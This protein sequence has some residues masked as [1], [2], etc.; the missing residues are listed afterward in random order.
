MIGSSLGR[1]AACLVACM[2]TATAS[3]ADWP[4]WRYDAAR[5]AA[6]PEQL[7]SELHLQW[8]REVSPR[9]PA[10]DDT[11]NRD[12]MTYDRVFEPI[13]L[14]GRLFVGFN[15]RD[16]LVAYDA[17][18]GAEL[19][20]FDTSG[21][22]RLPPVGWQGRVYFTSD[23]GRL[24]CVNAADGTLHWQFQGGP[25]GRQAIGN[26]RVISAW[27][28]RGGPVIR[29]GQV[30]FASSIWP[31]MGVFIYALN[32]QTGDVVWV[33]DDTG[34]QYIRQPHSAPSF[35]GVGPQGALVATQDVL[36]VPGGRSVPAAFDRHTGRQLYFEINAGGKGTGGSFVAANEE[37]WFVH[38]REKGTR[39]FALSNGVKTA[40]QPNEPVLAGDRIYSAEVVQ[41]RPIIRA[42]EAQTKTVLWEVD[43]DGRGDLILAGDTLYA[44]GSSGKLTAIRVAQDKPAQ[45][46]WSIPVEGQVERLLAANGQLFAVTLEGRIMAFG[47]TAPDTPAVLK[48]RMEPLAVDAA[49]EKLVSELL[50]ASPAEGYALWI[51]AEQTAL[52]DAL[53]AQS[54]FV[55]LKI[56]DEQAARVAS[57]RRRFDAAGLSGRV[58]VQPTPLEEFQPP[59][60]VFHTTIVGP[61]R[62][63]ILAG[64]PQ[65]MARIYESVR[66]YG[67]VLHLLADADQIPALR[68]DVSALK[69]ERAEVETTPHGVLIRRVGSLAGAGEWTHQYGDVAN[70]IKSNDQRVKLPLGI[71]WFGG[72]SHE[73]VLPRHG[74]GPPEQVVGGRLFIQGTNSLSARDVY[75]GR[76]L[77]KRDFENLGT[78]DVY[79]DDTYKETPLDTAYNQVHIPGANARGTNYVVTSDRVYIVEG[80]VCHVL[81][82]ATGESLMDIALPQVDPQQPNEWGFIGVSEDVLIGGVGFAKYRDRH[83]L[84]TTAIDSVL[85]RSKAGFGTKSLDRAASLALVGFDRRTGQQLW[86]VDAQHSFWHNGIV[87][88]NG[89]VFALDRNPKPVEEFLRRRG[90]SN[91]ESYRILAFDLRTGE[92]AWETVGDVFGTWL[93][94]SAAHD[95]LLQAGA[96][97]SDRLT[98]EVGQGMA[99]YQGRDG[100]VAWRKDDLKYTGPCVL[101]NDLIITN[102]N[103]YA[104]SA[105]A[106]HIVDGSPKYIDNPLTGAKQPWK[107]TRA[108]GCNN[109]IASEHLLTFRSGA[110]GFYDLLTES[111]TGNFGGF[112]SGCTSNLVVADGVLNAPDY[113][114]TCSCAYQN[115]TSLALVHMP[116]MDA[117][118]ISNS[119]VLEPDG[120]PVRHLGINLGA[121]GDCRDPHGVMWLE[122]PAVAGDS[123][124]LSIAFTGEPR[125]FQHHS[126]T[127]SGTVMSGTALPW[128][129][130]SGVEG[131]A[132]LRLQ[133]SAAPRFTLA[134]GWPIDHADDDAE[135][136]PD[137]EVTLDSSA[138]ELVRAEQDQILGLR[139]NNVPLERGVT[140]RAAALQFTCRSPGDEPTELVIRAEAV[141]NA[142]RF[143]DKARNLSGR[144]LTT[145]TV[146]WTPPAWIKEGDAAAAQRTPDLSPLIQ[147]IVSRPDWQPGNAIA[148]VITG[149]GRRFATAYRGKDSF[150]TQLVIDAETPADAK[151][152]AVAERPY[153]VRLHFGAPRGLSAERRRFDVV[154]NGRPVL[155]NVTLSAEQPA[156]V[157]TLDRVLL[158]D[159]LELDFLSHEGQPLLS[160]IEL[161]RLDE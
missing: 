99:V 17:S 26:R 1:I 38:T 3:A 72:N 28:A 141:G 57:L 125:Y 30:Y 52:V 148:F 155:E 97:G 91:P 49:S 133:L 93:G 9:E 138:L 53:A 37:S 118:T 130:S 158:G 153:R 105:G 100:A 129:L 140:I 16:K 22:V 69:L 110:A 117:W 88:G 74:H 102:A 146:R 27:P 10:W 152:P 121:P 151:R 56:V 58:T 35:A 92:Q 45:V 39:E 31:F 6:S 80:A 66:P 36:L 24:Y 19:W 131:I 107:I 134:T 160:G 23:D 116:E 11:L 122:H 149:S 90:K 14:D 98:S 62:A 161:H 34:A 94:Y 73:D 139:F 54:P 126:T 25:S 132:S 156:A 89:R 64:Q 115:Q 63:A 77:W 83:E 32:A 143:T 60:Y 96:S 127:M 43:A 124:N 82:P 76:V 135:E 119:A 154:H 15:D 111:G 67:G 47:A 71:L 59:P 2:L 44:A 81:D 29:D 157:H 65:Q 106:F 8:T 18:T 75:T 108:Y 114:R 46:A 85:S 79:Y 78:Y 137:G 40:F 103:S 7:P 5:S 42:C 84:E 136:T 109:I 12:L 13:V 120:G 95:L 48:D 128:V 144:S 20:T 50:Q 70:T 68:Q 86:R 150:P 145:A 61:E 147:E 41:D 87:A 101:H 55:E 51:G 123:P 142:P 112:K 21:P 113:T 159:R 33:N 104:E 4:Q